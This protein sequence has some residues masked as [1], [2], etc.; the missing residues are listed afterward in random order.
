MV[1]STS[2]FLSN[3]YQNW[4][5]VH[6]LQHEN[7]QTNK[8]TNKHTKK[9]REIT[10][11]ICSGSHTQKGELVGVEAC[12][13]NGSL[14]KVPPERFRRPYFMASHIFLFNK[15]NVNL[16][17]SSS[18]TNAMLTWIYLPLQQKQC[19]LGSIFLFNKMQCQS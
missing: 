11:I 6:D 14:F 2:S 5:I 7:K 1:E 3:L 18:S 9:D 4:R 10:I 13:F 16:D 15:C 17:L 19:Q 12:Y 8:Q